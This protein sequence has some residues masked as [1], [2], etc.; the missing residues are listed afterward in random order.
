[1]DSDD[2]DYDSDEALYRHQQKA[3]KMKNKDID[4]KKTKKSQNGFEVVPQGTCFQYPI[5]KQ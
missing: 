2:T 3:L 4:E 5:I 1:M